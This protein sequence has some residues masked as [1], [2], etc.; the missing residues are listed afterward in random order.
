MAYLSK[1]LDQMAAGWPACL[2]TI[3]A[4]ALLIKDADKLTLGQ[5]LF[6][7]TP[8]VIEGVRNQP[9]D[10]WLSNAHRTH[11][12]TLL[13]NPSQIIFQ[14]PVSLNPATLL[15]DP[16]LNCPLHQCEKLHSYTVPDLT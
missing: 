5:N 16:D 15:Q 11:Y 2:F 13:I 7:K 9:P 1:K 8:H 6:V 10:Q 3:A 12:Q 14:P 4:T